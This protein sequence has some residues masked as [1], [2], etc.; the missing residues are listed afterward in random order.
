MFWA[1]NLL[2]DESWLLKW[3]NFCELYYVLALWDG[4][5]TL[6]DGPL[7][8]WDGPLTLWDDPLTL[9]DGPLTLWD[10]P[11]TLWDGP[12]SIWDGPSTLWGGHLFKIPV[13]IPLIF[14]HLV[15]PLCKNY[16]FG[17]VLH[18]A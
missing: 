4:P 15:L 1:Y 11:L 9:W 7:T 3:S 13:I 6:W 8:L 2:D 5:L 14:F 10:V 12:L 18:I 17:Y 16:H